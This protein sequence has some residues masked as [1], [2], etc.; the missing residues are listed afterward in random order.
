[1]RL[2]NLITHLTRLA[3]AIALV[4]WLAGDR[5]GQRA[6][7]ALEALPDYDHSAE[8]EALRA[9]QRYSEA[10][11]VIEAGLADAQGEIQQ[12]QLRLLAQQVEAE[13]SDWLYRWSEVGSGAVTGSGDSPE[14]LA[15]A[16]A[17]DLFVFGDLR[18]LVIQGAKAA[19]GEDS[20][21]VIVALSALGLVLTAT[22]SLDLGT[23]MLKFA[24]RVGALTEGFARQLLRVSREAFDQRRWEPVGDIAEDAATLTRRSGPAATTAI[25]R[26]ID[27]PAQLR[28]ATRWADRPKGAFSLW[29]GGRPAL[30]LLE[31]GAEGER[32]LLKAATK[33][34]RG[35][36]LAAD[37]AGVLLKPHPLLGI[38]KGV[39]KGNVPELIG[40]WLRNQAP[41]LLGLA[42][43]WMLY[44]SLR[45]LGGIRRSLSR[46]DRL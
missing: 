19:R 40:P 1:M 3:A 36:Q 14:A 2:L 20:D 15:G 11:L 27:N 17:A 26:Q 7:D 32:L 46:P 44:E 34:R 37:Q 39:Y 24:R 23:A 8:A 18:D 22:P 38:I 29:L 9:E 4:V 30:G 31:Q 6:Y 13:R 45:L 10:L 12:A 33:G 35:I 5:A 21:E 42:V 25:F 41:A 16:I 43:A 28:L